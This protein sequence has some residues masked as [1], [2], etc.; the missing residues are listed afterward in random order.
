VAKDYLDYD[1]KFAEG[2]I[3]TAGR[4]RGLVPLF[5]A[6]P[7]GVMWHILRAVVELRG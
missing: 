4:K 3:D 1:L 7:E 5:Q 6:T 2:G